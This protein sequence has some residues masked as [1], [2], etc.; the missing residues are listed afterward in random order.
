MTS[1]DK[2]KIVSSLEF[3]KDP[4]G[5]LPLPKIPRNKGKLVFESFDCFECIFSISFIGVLSN[6]W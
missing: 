3:E 4:D 6:Q 2:N 5:Q 1:K